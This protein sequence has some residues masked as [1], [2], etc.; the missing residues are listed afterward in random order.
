M[1]TESHWITLFGATVASMLAFGAS[2]LSAPTMAGPGAPKLAET[3]P[4]A[5]LKA[6]V[7]AG[8]LA[9]ADVGAS[10]GGSNGAKV[11]AG[12]VGSGAQTGGAKV[13]ANVNAG[14]NDAAAGTA[15]VDAD[16]DTGGIAGTDN[17]TS[18][19]AKVGAGIDAGAGIGAAGA[20]VDADVNAGANPGVGG[21]K[22]GTDVNA[23]AE[24]DGEKV[25]AGVG[26]AAD[27]GT[28]SHTGL[29][30]DVSAGV[31]NDPAMRETSVSAS[32][33]PGNGTIGAD[34][35][36]LV[37]VSTSILL[38]LLPPA[39]PLE[40]HRAD[41]AGAT[42]IRD[43]QLAMLGCV[44]RLPNGDCPNEFDTKAGAIPQSNIHFEIMNVAD[45][46]ANATTSTVVQPTQ[47]VEPTYPN[48]RLSQSFGIIL[49]ADP[50]RTRSDLA[51]RYKIV[52]TSSQNQPIPPLD[53]SLLNS[54]GEVVGHSVL[55]A[56]SDALAGGQDNTFELR[57][58]SVPPDATRLTLTLVSPT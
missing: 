25:D 2:A 55:S 34:A 33:T 5:D 7:N 37:Q 52:N 35:T 19:G 58:R 38:P 32:E 44:D 23:S 41:G 9:G 54:A 17:K 56:P 16:V 27:G 48:A 3:L 24:A 15:K 46:A 28:E 43:T 11:S 8:G 18:G 29:N 31:T 39:R 1:P 50:I 13:D 51:V 47:E 10:I 14:V 26:V 20:N 21:A 12:A 6:G 40:S 4:V 53:V 49:L 36:A 22:V 42:G 30:T 45:G 57:I